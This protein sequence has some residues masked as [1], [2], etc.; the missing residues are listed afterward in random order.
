MTYVAKNVNIIGVLC[1]EES[2][3]A[4]A[5]TLS[6]S[7]DAV[8]PYFPDRKGIPA[9][10]KYSFNGELGGAPGNYGEI[11]NAVPFGATVQVDLPFVFKGGGAA[12]SAS[13]FVL[14][15]KL[16]KA[17]G[18]DATGSFAGGAEKWTFA[19]TLDSTIPTSLTVRIY[20]DN[21]VIPLSGVLCNYK[22][23][24]SGGLVTH[25]F[26]LMG[27]KGTV[28][29]S[30]SS[31]PAAFNY[32]LGAVVP[33][34]MAGSGLAIGSYASAIGLKSFDFDLGRVLQERVGYDA[35]DGHLGFIAGGR[36]PR[37]SCV[38]EK[39]AL[40]STPFHASGGLDPYQLW[41]SGNSF[42]LTYQHPGAQYNKWK[43]V[44]AQAQM[45]AEPQ[46]Q[47]VNGAACV[48]LD[49]MP[50]VSTPVANDDFTIVA[51]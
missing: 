10:L 17:A 49:F 13:V 14:F 40:Q 32:P 12:Y 29:D 9:T 47:E 44:L 4:T 46:R 50:Y 28:A 23:S 39:T 33:P 7:T 38:V 30:A 20:T 41:E 15:H 27:I 48:K 42:A 3:Y 34:T 5:V 26:S 21:E 22:C 37:F 45:S 25:T 1:K 43:L 8:Q 19:P 18:L 51:D 2:T 35:A 31:V 24:G 11:R 6:G 36:K 16:L